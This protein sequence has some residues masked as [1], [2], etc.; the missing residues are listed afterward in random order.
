MAIDRRLNIPTII[1]GGRVLFYTRIDE[2][3]V[4]RRPTATVPYGLAI[5]DLEESGIF[6]FTCE[7]DW[8]PIFDSWHA[9]VDEAKRQAAFEFDGVDSTWGQPPV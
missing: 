5:C 8:M 7:D 2:R 1:G 6:L 3:H 9:S 4:P